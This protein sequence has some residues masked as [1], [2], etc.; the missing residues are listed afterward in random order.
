MGQPGEAFAAVLGVSISPFLLSAY[1]L[2]IPPSAKQGSDAVKIHHSLELNWTPT[3]Q[4][5]RVTPNQ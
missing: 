1:I 4:L 5:Q 3:S 2:S